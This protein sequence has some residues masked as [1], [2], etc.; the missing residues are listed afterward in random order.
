M[1]PLSF[2]KRHGEVPHKIKNKIV[3]F[4]QTKIFSYLLVN[5]CV[6]NSER[7]SEPRTNKPVN[8]K[9]DFDVNYHRNE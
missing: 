1:A 7:H 9:I 4:L 8:R 3:S 2:Y 6:Y 5:I